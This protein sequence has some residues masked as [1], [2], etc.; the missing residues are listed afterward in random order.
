MHSVMSSR[1]KTAKPFTDVRR[2]FKEYCEATSIHGFKYFGEDRSIFERLWWA[3]VFIICLSGCC[4]MI[5]TIYDKY[6]R[7]PVIVTFATK[8]TPIYKIPFPAVTICPE[9][10]AAKE[11]FSYSATVL[12]K[13]DNNN[14]NPE[15]NQRLDYM[16]FLCDDYDLVPHSKNETFS[17]HFLDTIDEIKPNFLDRV[18]NCTFMG[19]ELKCRDILIPVLTDEGV[20]YSFNILDRSQIFN[21]L[22]NHYRKYHKSPVSSATWTIEKGYLDEYR[23]DTYPRRALLAGA[24]NGLTM[25]LVTTKSD[26]DYMCK[27]VQGYRV[28]LHTPM[29]MP[30]LK[31]EYFRVPLDQA[32]V[33]AVQPVMISTSE[34]VKTYDI[35]KRDC[36]FPFERQLKFFTSYSQLNCQLECLTNFTLATCGCVNIFMPRDHHTQICGNGKFECMKR[37]E[38]TLQTEGLYGRFQ[39]GPVKS[40]Q[41]DIDCDCM[42]LCTDLSYHTETSQTSWNWKEGLKSRSKQEFDKEKVHLSSLTVYF[43]FNH[44]ITSERNELYGPTD[45]L[46]NFGGLLGLFTGFS[47]LSLMEI[48][49]FLTLRIWCNVRMYGRW[50]EINR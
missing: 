48:I 12:N 29:R 39:D 37:A 21:D 10:K 28:I 47:I 18:Y 7:S 1:N 15:E 32:V 19:R 4:F 11:K 43:K 34:A 33:T 6:E 27:G 2:Y 31:Q 22:V 36:C 5:Y 9:S 40:V 46:A 14:S 17:N 44:F 45:F 42:P 23:F 25:H 8:E 16:S 38:S 20:C 49:Y 30:R 13:L 26:I 3:V 24:S 50:I 35:N 41:R